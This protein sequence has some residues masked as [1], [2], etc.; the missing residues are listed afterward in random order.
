MFGLLPL[1][2]ALLIAETSTQMEAPLAPLTSWSHLLGAVGGSLLVWLV[3]GEIAARVI[4]TRG[5]R[6]WLSRWDWFVQGLVLG[7]YAWVCFG[8]GWAAHQ[9]FFGVKLFLVA[10]APWVLMQEIGPAL[11]A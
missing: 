4:A 11:N 3:L 6:Q 7:W 9:P 8:W 2:F 10:L 5:R 1:L